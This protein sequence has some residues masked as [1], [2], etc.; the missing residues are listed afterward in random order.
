MAQ[1]EKE[2]EEL[3]V[4]ELDDQDLE[5]ATGGDGNCGCPKGTSGNGNCDC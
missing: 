1:D 4:T 2:P 3:E 5:E